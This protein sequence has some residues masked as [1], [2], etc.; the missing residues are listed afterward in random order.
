MNSLRDWPVATAEQWRT[1]CA[2]QRHTWFRL[3]RQ[4]LCNCMTCG[5]FESRH[6]RQHVDSRVDKPSPERAAPA[7]KLGGCLASPHTLSWSSL[8]S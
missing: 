1:V 6:W 5:E 8:A 3:Y 2:I 4:E 7:S